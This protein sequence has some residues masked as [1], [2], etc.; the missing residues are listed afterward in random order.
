M[1]P[2]RRSR[3]LR[4]SVRRALVLTATTV[5]AAAFA[6]AGW[7][8]PALAVPAAASA[9]PANASPASAVSVA[10]SGARIAQSD[11]RIAQSDARAAQS[12]ARQAAQAEP[13]SVLVFSK[14]AGFRHDSI[15]AGI[16]AIQQLGADNGFTVDTTE[17]G[18]AFT[19]ANLAQ[20]AGRGLAVHDRRRAR[21][22]PAGR[23][24]A[25][26]PGRRRLRRHPRRL[27]HRV[28]WAWYGELVGAY[29]NVAPGA[30]SRPP[31]RWRTRR[32]RPPRTCRTWTRIDEWYNFRTNPRG[33]CTC[34][35]AWTSAA[36]P[37][38][39]RDGRRPPDRVVPRL[40]RRPLLVHRRAA[41]PSESYS[42]PDFLAHLL[43]G[44]QTA[45]GVVER[46][47]R[48]PR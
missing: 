9:T 37:R 24:R 2:D 6:P 36:T 39:R 10:Q 27:R 12:D 42:E 33:T 31:S 35:P 5:L 3:G 18:G 21:R 30:T 13:F 38:H 45:A 1:P 41:T 44:I 46:R 28:H 14:T 43:G 15:P 34:W 26:H 20:Y 11:A 8:S 22:R 7:A 25:L 47:L 40:R 17:D 19:D 4:G 23:V 48:A 16:A 29:F 32:T